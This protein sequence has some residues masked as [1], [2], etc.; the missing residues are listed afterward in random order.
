MRQH[1]HKTRPECP[2]GPISG[3]DRHH[4]LVVTENQLVGTKR[5]EGGRG[6]W[7]RPAVVSGVFPNRAQEAAF[8]TTRDQTGDLGRWSYASLKIE[9]GSLEIRVRKT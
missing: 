6:V 1:D 2:F 4:Y 3:Y 8:A 5:C 9:D 7:Q